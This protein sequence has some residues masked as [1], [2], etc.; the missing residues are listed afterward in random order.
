[1][2]PALASLVAQ[3]VKN[4]T[5]VQEMQIRSP[6]WEDSL[7]KETAAHF[8]VLAWRIPWTKEPG[9]LYSMGLRNPTQPSD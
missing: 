7:E 8:N 5:A 1:M 9:E 4:P 2:C 3:V 6:D